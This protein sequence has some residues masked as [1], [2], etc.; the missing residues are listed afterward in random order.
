MQQENRARRRHLVEVVAGN[1][2]NRIVERG[3]YAPG[4][5][6]SRTILEGRLDFLQAAHQVG[7]VVDALAQ[8]ARWVAAVHR[9]G[10]LRLCPQESFEQVG[11]ALD[12]AGHQHAVIEAFVQRVRSPGSAVVEIA[13][14]DDDA[15]TYR[16]MRRLI[17]G[18]IHG[19]DLARAED[20]DRSRHGRSS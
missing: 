18:G 5:Q 8:P 2:C 4:D 17:D 13:D 6:R 14:L 20:G 19:D 1:G 10:I 9:P 15:V 16:D 11:M 12:E 7:H 3:V